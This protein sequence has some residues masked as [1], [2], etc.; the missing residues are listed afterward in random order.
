[1]PEFVEGLLD[2]G[3]LPCGVVEGDRVAA[4]EDVLAFGAGD[5]RRRQG[6]LD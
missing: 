3:A 1:M 5:D 6:V 2:E 4:L